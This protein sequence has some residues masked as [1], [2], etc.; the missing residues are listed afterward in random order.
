MK[1]EL[2]EK[3]KLEYE[4]SRSWLLTFLMAGLVVSIAFANIGK[5]LVGWYNL[6]F[7][8]LIVILVIQ[9]V[10]TLIVSERKFEELMNTFK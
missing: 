3:L 9:I 10:I 4:H 8:V 6:I 2:R 1:Q 5:N 7:L